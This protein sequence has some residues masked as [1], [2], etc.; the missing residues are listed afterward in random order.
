MVCSLQLVFC[1][2]FIKT[3]FPRFALNIWYCII[4]FL[5]TSSSALLLFTLPQCSRTLLSHSTL[6]LCS[7]FYSALRKCLFVFVC[8]SLLFYKLCC[9]TPLLLCHSTPLLLSGF[10]KLVHYNYF[11]TFGLLKLILHDW[12]SMCN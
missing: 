4:D 7:H 2:W 5:Q 11:S 9:F 6:P 10:L 12:F 1:I 8:L 3:W